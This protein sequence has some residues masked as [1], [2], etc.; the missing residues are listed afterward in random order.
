MHPA[1]PKPPDTNRQAQ[2]LRFTAP[3]P[4]EIAS[5]RQCRVRSWQDKDLPAMCSHLSD[6]QM[7]PHLASAF[8]GGMD[9]ARAEHCL[10]W[11]LNSQHAFCFAVALLD[12]DEVVGGLT[13]EIGSGF[14][15]RSAEIHGWLARPWWRSGIAREATTAF[16]DWLFN[17]Q[18]MLRVHAAPYHLNRASIGTLRAS[19]FSFEGRLRCS[20]LKDGVV[21]DQMQYAKINPRHETTP[22][23]ALR[24]RQP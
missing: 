22:P 19:G 18:H 4:Q 8:A 7:W 14:H 10:A 11:F 24:Q 9:A 3:A 20:V 12:S 21:M 5:L 6:A 1:Q 16:T 17:E 13:A 15:G 23:P 2:L